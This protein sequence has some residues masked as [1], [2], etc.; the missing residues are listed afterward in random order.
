MQ[1]RQTLLGAKRAVAFAVSAKEFAIFL[2]RTIDY[3]ALGYVCVYIHYP[4]FSYLSHS[5]LVWRGLKYTDLCVFNK[6]HR[7]SVLF[8]ATLSKG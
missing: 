1:C 6:A 5:T 4:Q 3:K 2:S 8:V 7:W